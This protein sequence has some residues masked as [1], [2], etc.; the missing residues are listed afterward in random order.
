MS[1]MPF[2]P[3]SY[4]F[5]SEQL[6][7]LLV[8]EQPTD[9]PPQQR[10]VTNAHLPHPHLTRAHTHTP[11]H[12]EP[13]VQSVLVSEQKQK[14]DFDLHPL[15]SVYPLKQ[16]VFKSITG[17]RSSVLIR[18]LEKTDEA[19]PFRRGNPVTRVRVPEAPVLD[20]NPDHVCG[21]HPE[22]WPL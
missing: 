22:R 14:L 11:C 21:M 15:L 7:L 9:C 12:T 1:P 19:K 10:G 4:L 6:C 17:G 5:P 3:V 8:R 18:M 13:C 16:D 2:P 20:S